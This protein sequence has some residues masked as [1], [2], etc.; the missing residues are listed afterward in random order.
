MAAQPPVDCTEFVD[1]ASGPAA[2]AGTA[3]PLTDHAGGTDA[4]DCASVEA[5]A[6]TPL[7]RDAVRLGLR[8]SEYEEI[9]R[10]LGREPSPAELGMFGVMWSEHCAYKHSK[11]TLRR[12]PSRASGL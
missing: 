8:P 9:C 2:C 3:T 4:N 6:Q 1:S 12:L 11:A 5:K 7:A 10:R